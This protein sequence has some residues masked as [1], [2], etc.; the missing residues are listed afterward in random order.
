M[1]IIPNVLLSERAHLH[2]R[3]YISIKSLDE[4]K[5]F[6]IIF[7][8]WRREQK[9]TCCFWKDYFTFQCHRKAKFSSCQKMFFSCLFVGRGE[10][11]CRISCGL[12]EDKYEMMVDWHKAFVCLWSTL[13]HQQLAVEA[14]AL[15]NISPAS[16]TEERCFLLNFNLTV[17]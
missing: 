3:G 8:W 14:Q 13:S 4:S 9:H 12:K 2:Q 7:V 16:F 15:M 10:E 6:F 17:Y 1:C 11:E 5:L